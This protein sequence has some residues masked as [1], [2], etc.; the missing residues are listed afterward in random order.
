M[1]RCG[2]DEDDDLVVFDT[3]PTAGPSAAG[4]SATNAEATKQQQERVWALLEERWAAP[5]E[6]GTAGTGPQIWG[7]MKPPLKSG[8][9]WD[10]HSML[11]LGNCV[12]I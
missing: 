10:R 7:L 6:A 12:N 1:G 5:S 8:T 2:Q 3:S 11:W 9:A 4:P